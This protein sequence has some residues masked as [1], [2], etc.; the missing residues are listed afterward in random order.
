MDENALMAVIARLLKI[1]TGSVTDDLK[2]GDI[3]QW[4]SLAHVALVVGIEE[5]FGFS[6][7]SADIVKIRDVRSLLAIVKQKAEER[8]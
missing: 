5:E 2:P 3:P 4:D 7:D 6:F 8:K 1:E